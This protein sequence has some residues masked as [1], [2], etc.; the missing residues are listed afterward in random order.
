MTAKEP[1]YSNG[2]FFMHKGTVEAPEEMVDGTHPLLYKPFH[3]YGLLGFALSEGANLVGP[4]R[5]K[6]YAGIN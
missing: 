1:R 5:L 4:D 6:A 2:F 3:H